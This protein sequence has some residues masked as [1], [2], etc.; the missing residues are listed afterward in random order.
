MS[1][2]T[3][4]V[5]FAIRNFALG[6][7][8]AGVFAF[9]EVARAEP[10]LLQV[11]TK[12]VPEPVT[13]T[14]NILHSWVSDHEVLY[15]KNGAMWM[16]DTSKKTDTKLDKLSDE[17]FGDIGY[18][19]VEASPAGGYVAWSHSDS[20]W[21][22]A[23]IGGDGLKEWPAPLLSDV[24]WCAD[25]AYWARVDQESVGEYDFRSIRAVIYRT[26]TPAE[27]ES[28]YAL[29][30]GLRDLEILAIPARTTVIARFKDK[31]YTTS[32]HPKPTR[33]PGGEVEFTFSGFTQ[34]RRVQTL[35]VWDLSSRTKTAQW[36]IDLPG[37]VQEV[38]ASP[39]GKRLAWLVQGPFTSS[40]ST[41]IWV[42]SLD[43]T[44]LHEIGS[45]NDFGISEILWVPG[46]KAISF[47][48]NYWLYE[49]PA[50]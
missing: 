33:A 10:D 23:G 2:F 40:R 27:K 43:G 50:P 32:M 34:Y 22:T 39:D 18:L 36:T 41:S 44:G 16:H 3:R 20:V 49:A 11:A 47:H 24:A 12:L 14:Y 31:T 15:V 4:S 13:G 26:T 1:L 5:R 38:A 29:P 6:L 19:M 45:T 37:V 42:S 9:A 35:S 28:I 30:P 7:V 46:D 25:G 8:L 48:S 21:E 17:M